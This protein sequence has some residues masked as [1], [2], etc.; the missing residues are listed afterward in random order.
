MQITWCPWTMRD[1]GLTHTPWNNELTVRKVSGG[2]AG[3]F[4]NLAQLKLNRRDRDVDMWGSEYT[5]PVEEDE[6]MDLDMDEGD[7]D[8]AFRWRDEPVGN[9]ESVGPVGLKS[10][11]SLGH[12]ALLWSN[13]LRERK[14]ASW[15]LRPHR[16][17]NI[18]H[19]LAWQWRTWRQRSKWAGSLGYRWTC[20]KRQIRRPKHQELQSALTNGERAGTASAHGQFVCL[21]CFITCLL[22]SN[23]CMW[24]VRG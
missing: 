15:G 16:C 19:T 17:V 7:A 13:G 20:R 5:A 2:A 8:E 11:D 14:Q 22:L 6:K 1:S 9:Q 4:I 3:R 24:P 10:R 21:S 18:H 23:V 12:S